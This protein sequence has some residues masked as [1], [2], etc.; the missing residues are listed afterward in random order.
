MILSKHRQIETQ[1]KTLKA[2]FNNITNFPQYT[3]ILSKKKKSDTYNEYYT[4]LTKLIKQTILTLNKTLCLNS[5]GFLSSIT[6]CGKSYIMI[7]KYAF[8]VSYLQLEFLV[9]SYCEIQ[10][11]LLHIAPCSLFKI[12]PFFLY[13]G[14]VSG[15]QFENRIY[16]RG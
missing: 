9:V 11:I 7:Q 5:L 4:H 12:L 6:A 10:E 1:W 2:L 3:Q 16:K 15:L 13:Y 14:L 8:D